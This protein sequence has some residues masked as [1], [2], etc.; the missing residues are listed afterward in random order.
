M[1]G[2]DEDDEDLLEN[3]VEK[4]KERR[5]LD[6]EV[7]SD[8]DRLAM[9]LYSESKHFLPYW[10]SKDREVSEDT[11]G[12]IFECE[13]T[14]PD[15]SDDEEELVEEDIIDQATSGLTDRHWDAVTVLV[16]KNDFISAEELAEE[17]DITKNYARVLIYNVKQEVDLEMKK[18]GRRKLYKIPEETTDNMVM[19]R[20]FLSEISHNQEQDLETL[21]EKNSDYANDGD[22]FK[23]FRMVEDSGL[24]SVEKGI[25]VRMSDKMQRTFNLLEKDA[26]VDDETIEDTLSDLRNYANI[27]QVYLDEERD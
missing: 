4:V 22:P 25:A 19:R 2:L 17:L 27:L 26:D 7:K 15:S 12:F 21:K 10:D 3:G 13:I 9:K 5:E 20:K 18:D 1:L 23:N 24:V 16:D 8:R 6:E 14:M 11:V